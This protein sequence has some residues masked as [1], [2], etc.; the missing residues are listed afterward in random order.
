MLK[1]VTFIFIFLNLI[2]IGFSDH[3]ADLDIFVDE[4]GKT[5]ISGF[6]D[7]K[8]LI[9][10]ESHKFT[11]KNGEMWIFN[12][13]IDEVF[14]EFVFNLNLPSGAQ[15]NY[16]KTTPEFRI[17]QGDNSNLKIV[18][19][20]ENRELSILVQYSF[21]ELESSNFSFLGFFFSYILLGLTILFIILFVIIK[22]VKKSKI[23]EE[24]VS[25]VE[26]LE[27]KIIGH[28]YSKL[29]L[30]QRQLN[31]I[32]ILKKYGEI[33]QKNLE[34]E[35]NIPKSSI[36]RNLQSMSA[37]NIICIKKNGITNIISL[38]KYNK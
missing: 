17:T 12:L 36:S 18:G 35:L 22:K 10:S 3:Y 23:V 4:T 21:E 13:S 11:S 8:G 30:N 15:T 6:T 5:T 37:K 25:E 24:I 33:S 28:D 2:F 1:Q 19:I 9:V 27:D 31:I 38:L 20:G 29:N 32:E 26:E 14:S 34:E 7:Y 16:I